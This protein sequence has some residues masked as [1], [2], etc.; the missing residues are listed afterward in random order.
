MKIQKRKLKLLT[1]SIRQKSLYNHVYILLYMSK[2]QNSSQ[3][4][5]DLHFC[6]LLQHAFLQ[7]KNLYPNNT[8][9]VVKLG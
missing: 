4:Q 5:N 6:K 9:V 8:T 2:Q 7:L 3:K 1:S